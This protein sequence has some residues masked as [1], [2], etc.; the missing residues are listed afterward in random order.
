[1]SLTS[2]SAQDRRAFT[3]IELLVVIAI[4]GILIALL[5]PAVQKVREAANRSRCM[6]NL[7][8]LGIALMNYENTHGA[9]PPSRTSIPAKRSWTVVGLPY[10]EEDNVKNLYKMDKAWNH[11][12]NYSII[13]SNVRLFSCPSV[14]PGRFNPLD[15]NPALGIGDYGSVNEVKPD[16]YEENGF[17]PPTDRNGILE[18]DKACRIAQI[19]D[20]TSNT[21]MVGEDAGR[22]TLWQVG[23]NQGIPTADG[24][25]WADPDCGFSLSGATTDGKKIGGP[26]VVNCTNDSEFYSFHPG[27]INVCMGDGSARFLPQTI[28]LNILAALCTRGAGESVSGGDF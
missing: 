13:T 3:L 16:F 4:I 18:K 6:S 2:G 25:G 17:S 9:F 27:G 10:I 20:G 26:C 11:P 12:D 24:W 5:L 28:K 22:P 23:K 8:Q 14:P 19:T 21:I 7:R 15:P 1:V